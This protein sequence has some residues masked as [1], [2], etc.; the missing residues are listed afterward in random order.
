[1]EN[2]IQLENNGLTILDCFCGAGIGAI[3]AEKAG[4]STIYAFDKNPHAVRNFNKNIKNVANVIDVNDVDINS[5][6]YADIITGGFPCKSWSNAGKREGEN[7]DVNG[8]LAKKLVSIIINKQPKAF[9][10]ENVKGFVNKKNMNH[11]NEIKDMLSA[12]YNI[13]WD[14]LNCYDYG[15]PQKRERVFIIGINKSI[16]SNIFKFPEKSEMKFSINDALYGLPEIPNNINNHDYNKS[17]TLRKDEEPYAHKVPIGGNWKNLNESDAKAFMKNAFYSGG[18]RTGFLH[19]VD[20]N[21]PAKTI[22][23][24]P[25]GKNTAQIL[26]LSDNSHRR[27]TVRESLRLQ[28]VPDSFVFDKETPI[29]I[30]YERCSGIPSLMSYKLLIEIKKALE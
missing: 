24:T 9:L 17:Y 11:F 22:M 23:S 16:E 12:Y 13:T 27:Y 28:T 20:P 5:L 26:R 8:G 4:Y 18:G 21:E 3:G 15:V 7:C 19:V 30:Q 6:P 1:M 2:I 29:K 10:M 25:M 14:V